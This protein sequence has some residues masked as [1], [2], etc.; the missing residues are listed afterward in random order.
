M[1]RVG[2]VFKWIA[3]AIVVLIAALYAFNTL[4]NR[5]T[6]PPASAANVSDL[7]SLNTALQTYKVKFGHYPDTLQQ[8]GVAAS[9]PASELGAGLI[10]SKLAAGNAH[11]YR[12]TY[13]KS[14]QGYSIHADPDG[15]ENNMHLFTDETSEVRFKRKK[16][17]DR[18]SDVLQ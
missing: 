4:Y 9:G 12:Y 14:G 10:G 3:I 5:V 2:K 13:S 1:A 7:R 15:A 11:G 6:G 18:S 16:P 17:A 8:L